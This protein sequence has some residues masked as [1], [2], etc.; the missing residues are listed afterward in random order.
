MIK[1]IWLA[2]SNQVVCVGAK[3]YHTPKHYNVGNEKGELVALPTE[4][5]PPGFKGQ[6][7]HD[8]SA[9]KYYIYYFSQ[10]DLCVLPH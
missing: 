5:R 1:T 8:S 10:K 7:E 4:T 2:S 9:I 6:N 3:H